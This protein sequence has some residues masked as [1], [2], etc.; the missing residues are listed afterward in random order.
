MKALRALLQAAVRN[1]IS[2]GFPRA[3][4]IAVASG[5]A[6]NEQTLPQENANI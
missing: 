6:Y 3:S 2:S 4:G 5:K 1:G